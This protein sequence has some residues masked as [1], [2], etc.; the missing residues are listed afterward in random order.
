M[1][2]KGT[3]VAA[4]PL[5]Q[6]EPKTASLNRLPQNMVRLR[7]T[8]MHWLLPPACPRHPSGGMRYPVLSQ[9]KA[10]APSGGA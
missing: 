7:S 8:S 6:L 9:V 1:L 5:E 10:A 3:V 2:L 4:R